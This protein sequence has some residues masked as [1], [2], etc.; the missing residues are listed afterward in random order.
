M[1]NEL[2]ILQVIGHVTQGCVIQTNQVIYPIMTHN[3]MDCKLRI[4][5]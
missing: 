5:L 4:K 3:I 2:V 1:M